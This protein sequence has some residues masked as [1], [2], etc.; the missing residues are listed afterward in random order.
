M[1]LRSALRHYRSNFK[2][3]LAFALLLVFVPVF[4]LLEAV[5][6]SSGSVFLDYSLNEVNSL[7]LFV[8]LFLLFMTFYALLVSV[9]VFSVRNSLSK[10][11]AHFYLHEMIQ[12]FALRLFVFFVVYSLVLYGFFVAMLLLSVPLVAASLVVLLISL[13]LFFV[14]QAIVVDEEYIGH[15]IAN[16]L[17]FIRSNPKALLQVLVVGCVLLAAASVVGEAFDVFFVGSYAS[18]LL[19]M[20]FVL[21]F[22]EIMKTYL[23]MLKFDLIRSHVVSDSITP[24]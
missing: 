21:P 9:V 4:Q 17:E 8:P 2:T 23:Y 12:K 24:K 14:P 6:V 11:K 13:F 7:L 15:A 10:L 22:V 1:I 18:L 20:V 16:N 3:A 5:S 19:T